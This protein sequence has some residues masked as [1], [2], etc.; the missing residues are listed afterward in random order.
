VTDLRQSLI[1]LKKKNLYNHLSLYIVSHR[2][3]NLECGWSLH[4]R[5]FLE[6]YKEKFNVNRL[7]KFK[8]FRLFLQPCKK[9]IRISW[10]HWLCQDRH[11][12]IKEIIKERR[13]FSRKSHLEKAKK[14][15]TRFL[16]SWL[17]GD[18]F[19]QTLEYVIWVLCI[20]LCSLTFLLTTSY[21]IKFVFEIHKGLKL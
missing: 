7:L 14:I 15:V 10:W 18:L 8:K 11:L 12:K 19:N 4:R 2:V 3:L 17:T 9:T 5:K 16:V 13:S 1:K 6:N 20:F 21:I